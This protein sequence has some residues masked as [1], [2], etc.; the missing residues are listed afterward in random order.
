LLESDTDGKEESR[1]REIRFR[2]WQGGYF[3]YWGFMGKMFASLGDNN[4]E[5]LSI[6]DKQA[7]TQQF[8]GLKDKNGKEIYEGDIIESTGKLVS[9]VTGKDTGEI[10]KSKYEVVWS[11]ENAHY[12][13]KRLTDG[14]IQNGTGM[15]QMFMT[16]YYEVIG[17]VFENPELTAEFLLIERKPIDK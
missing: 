13:Q 7:R 14:Y 11:E 15:K 10:V 6:E 2:T 5:S 17:N 3:S 4:I 1:V 8:T 16:A 9:F 12:A